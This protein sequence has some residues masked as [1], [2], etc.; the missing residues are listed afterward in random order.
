MILRNGSDNNHSGGMEG[1]ENQRGCGKLGRF[2]GNKC[3]VH[4]LGRSEQ[5]DIQILGEMS[6]AQQKGL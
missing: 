6:R 5:Y 2:K 4:F 1:N 3:L